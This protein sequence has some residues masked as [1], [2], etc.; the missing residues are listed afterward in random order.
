VSA[1]QCTVRNGSPVT[2]ANN[3]QVPVFLWQDVIGETTL[4]IV[5]SLND[6]SLVAATASFLLLCFHLSSC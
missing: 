6:L 3:W 2:C 4:K 1:F 5:R